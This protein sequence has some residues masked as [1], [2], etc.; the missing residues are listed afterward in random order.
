[1]YGMDKVVNDDVFVALATRPDLQSLEF[2]MAVT[3]ELVSL[4]KSRRNRNCGGGQLF[5]QLRKLIWI[6]DIDGLFSFLP[7]LTQL[8]HLEA[9]ILGRHISYVKTPGSLSDIATYCPKLQVLELR[10]ATAEDLD[11]ELVK[12]STTAEDIDISPDE[13]VELA[14]RSQHLEHMEISG[15]HVRAPGLET[16]HIAK[17]VEALP[18]LRVL[19]LEFQ[20]ALTEA[21]LVE[22][23][24]GCGKTLTE[25]GLWGSY[26]LSNLEKSGISFPLLRD[27]VLEKVVSSATPDSTANEAAN[28]ARLLKRVAPNLESFIIIVRDSFAR[29]VRTRVNVLINE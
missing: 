20:C 26:N 21:A 16:V 22:V 10:Y 3:P 6:G 24:K 4:A 27:L 28:N 15:D 19:V 11:F 25:C 17:I 1:M 8:T 29:E 23:G 13:L 9:T 5:P 14:Q 18:S 2:Q 12:P 7:H